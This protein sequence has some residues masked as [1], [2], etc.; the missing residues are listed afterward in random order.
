MVLKRD[1]FPRLAK[2]HGV[3]EQYT[4]Q[5]KVRAYLPRSATFQFP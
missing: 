3:S 2:E 1:Y 5:V 4:E